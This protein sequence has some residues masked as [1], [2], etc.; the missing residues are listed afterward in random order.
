MRGLF[1]LAFLSFLL[2]SN[3]YC[4]IGLDE[5]V[6]EWKTNQS[7]STEKLNFSCGI[8]FDSRVIENPFASG[9]TVLAKQTEGDE[10]IVRLGE[11]KVG[12]NGEEELYIE[13][14]SRSLSAT[15]KDKNPFSF[16]IPIS[17][18]ELKYRSKIK[19][20]IPIESQKTKKICV[21]EITLEKE[22]GSRIFVSSEWTTPGSILS[23]GGGIV[24]LQ[25][26][27][28]QR[29]AQNSYPIDIYFQ[30]F[31]NMNHGWH[32]GISGRIYSGLNSVKM[33]AAVPS[34][35]STDRL[36]STHF[37][38][39]YTFRHYLTRALY[40]NYDGGL[41]YAL[42]QVNQTNANL[43]FGSFLF[44]QRFLINVIGG[45]YNPFIGAKAYIGLGLGLEHTWV[46]GLVIGTADAYG[47]D[48]GVVA[49]LLI[50]W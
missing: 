18:K 29:L 3:A 2:P 39:G 5:E 24:L 13:Q 31:L 42:T 36:N 47:H 20:T 30:S 22:P 32:L 38:G 43:N 4:K 9:V 23:M 10:Q 19:I 6:E 27:G 21:A 40:L 15:I 28:I 7:N 8:V 26:S 50:G 17:S 37:F 33:V 45:S 44:T 34:F 25:G 1:F 11:A 35:Q 46:P 48:V 12:F 14:V 41:G 49:R 16:S